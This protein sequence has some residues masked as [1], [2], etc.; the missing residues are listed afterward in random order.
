MKNNALALLTLLAPLPEGYA[1]YLSLTAKLFWPVWV[2]APSS[3]IV[4]TIG[5][6]AIQVAERMG[7]YNA[8]L[9]L[10]EKTSH[11]QAP[12]KQAYLSLAIWFVGSTTLILFLDSVMVAIL[13]PVALVVIGASGSYVRSLSTGQDGRE[14]ERAEY[15]TRVAKKRQEGRK[16]SQSG[17]R[18]SQVQISCRYAGAGCERKFAKQNSA[19]AHAKSCGFKPTISMPI[20]V[21]A[22]KIESKSA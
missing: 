3:F 22:K 19:N 9:R 13:A 7:A 1:V 20:D 5:F 6:F 10:D 14:A 4:A 21:S 12:I 16:G 18:N 17:R 15:R 8:T 2:A 11:M